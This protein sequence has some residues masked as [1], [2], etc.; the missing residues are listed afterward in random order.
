MGRFFMN[1]RNMRSSNNPAISTAGDRRKPTYG[2]KIGGRGGKKEGRKEKKEE[3]EGKG[4]KKGRRGGK[5]EGRKEKKAKSHGR[6]VGGLNHPQKG[7]SQPGLA[8]AT[9]PA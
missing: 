3:E 8:P 6:P 5:K 2:K 9:W 1:G 4:R 7:R